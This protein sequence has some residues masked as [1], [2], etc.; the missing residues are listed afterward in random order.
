MTTAAR[1]DSTAFNPQFP[2]TLKECKTCEQATPHEIRCS[3][4]LAVTVCTVCRDR[5][6]AF[7]LAR[8]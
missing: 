4:S 2:K 7:E 1:S 3:A 6:L 8:D 5:A